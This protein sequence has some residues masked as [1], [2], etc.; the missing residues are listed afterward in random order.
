MD[1]CIKLYLQIR[2]LWLLPLPFVWSLFPVL[3]WI[4]MNGF[5]LRGSTSNRSRS[6]RKILQSFSL[7]KLW[8]SS[9]SLKGKHRSCIPRPSGPLP[10]IHTEQVFPLLL[11]NPKHTLFDLALFFPTFLHVLCFST[12]SVPE[13]WAALLPRPGGT[14]GLVSAQNVVSV[15]QTHKHKAMWTLTSQ[16]D[17]VLK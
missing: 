10:S 2:I 16:V 17:N 5:F 9:S 3:V 6:L 14:S 12:N 4:G 1:S 13:V 15:N 8:H 11:P 7:R